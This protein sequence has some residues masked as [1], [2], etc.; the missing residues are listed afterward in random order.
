M[1]NATSSDIIT[2]ARTMQEKVFNTFGII[3]QPECE[4]VGFKN[5]PLL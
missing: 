3:P 1:D 5:Y 4:L 2:V